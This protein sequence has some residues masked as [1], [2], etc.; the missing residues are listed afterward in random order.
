MLRLH[1]A[2]YVI[3]DP[4]LTISKDPL[5]TPQRTLLNH[6]P[7]SLASRGSSANSDNG[8]SSNV[9]TKSEGW[10]NV[11]PEEVC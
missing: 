9:R 10:G 1:L 6:N 2:P 5:M 11:C 8:F 3:H 7:P 4:L